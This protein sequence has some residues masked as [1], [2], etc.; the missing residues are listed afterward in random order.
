VDKT[1]F[2]KGE[3]EP[4]RKKSQSKKDDRLERVQQKLIEFAQFNFNGPIPVSKKG[5]DVDTI[6]NDLNALGEKLEAR[7]IQLQHK[8]K[9]INEIMDIL[10]KYTVMDFSERME[11]SEN[12]DEIDAI[13]V[14][15]NTLCEELIS[16]IEQL[17]ANEEKVRTSQ[18]IF[19]TIFYKSPVMNSITDATTG[20]FIE[21]N[22]NFIEF[23]EFKKE[24]IINKSSLDLNLIPHPEKRAE[25]IEGI[26]KN[27]YS[28]DVL[29]EI[30]TKSKGTKWLSSSAHAVNIDGRDCYIT[31][32]IDIT[33]RKKAED[34]LQ[35]VNKELEAFSYSVSHDLRAPLRAVNGYSE[36]LKEDYGDKLGEEG[37]RIIN[38]IKYNATKMGTLIDD[39]LTFSRLGRKEV[40]SIQI[41]MNQLVEGVLVDLNKSVKYKAEIKINTLHSVKADYGLLSQVVFNLVSNAIK[42]SSKKEFPT[43]E[44]S[45]NEDDGKIIFSI[46]DNGAGFDMRYYD[47][48]FGVF[49]RLHT[50]EEFEGT[51][52]GLAI[53]QRI[54]GKHGGKVWAKSKLTEG[55]TF[56]FSLPKN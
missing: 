22:E 20:K 11:V 6:I 38:N 42:Y 24:E 44:I 21:V 48:L 19:S 45:S 26:K 28:R 55:T 9:R 40:D 7:S 29:I 8:E 52:V 50:Q 3:M 18:K 35:A 10:L 1:I 56:F 23:C 4:I 33:E 14:G 37:N 31:A 41:N 16:H 53:V 27:G 12:G 36:M 30:Q 2:M 32:M 49:Q 39:L 47:K 15:L 54:I 25:I 51:G 5:D 34:Q 13:S 46:K 43:V 17:K